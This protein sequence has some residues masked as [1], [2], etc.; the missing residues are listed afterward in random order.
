[1]LQLTTLLFELSRSV[2][3][4]LLP[5]DSGG[6]AQRLQRTAVR[7]KTESDQV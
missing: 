2:E 1:M 4:S 5:T 7:R 6:G 3:R